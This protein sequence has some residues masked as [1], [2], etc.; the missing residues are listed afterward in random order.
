MSLSMCTYIGLGYVMIYTQVKSQVE[1]LF[2]DW[3][4]AVGEQTSFCSSKL[5]YMTEMMTYK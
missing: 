3:N 1:I 2:E 5:G 4:G